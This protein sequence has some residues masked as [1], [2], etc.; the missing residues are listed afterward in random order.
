MTMEIEVLNTNKVDYIN[1][2]KLKLI[3]LYF[4]QYKYEPLNQVNFK[5]LKK[6]NYWLKYLLMPKKAYRSYYLLLYTNYQTIIKQIPNK[7]KNN[8]KELLDSLNK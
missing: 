5:L 4:K 6:D 8:L 3:N 7:E 2:L 1:S